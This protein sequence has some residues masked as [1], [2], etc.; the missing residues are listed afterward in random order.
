LIATA[1]EK[2]TA[3]Y[4]TEQ[5]FPYNV[6]NLLITFDPVENTLFRTLGSANAIGVACGNWRSIKVSSINSE[7]GVGGEY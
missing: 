1:L 7:S 6:W 3:G 5:A 4:P 2:H